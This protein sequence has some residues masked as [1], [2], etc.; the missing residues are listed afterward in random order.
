MRAKIA[1]LA[2]AITVTSVHAGDNSAKYLLA[3]MLSGIIIAASMDAKR[4]QEQAPAPVVV[5]ALSPSMP[6]GVDRKASQPAPVYVPPPA[7]VA[8]ARSKYLEACQ[9]YGFSAGDCV[10]IWDGKIIQASGQ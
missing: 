1:A 3:G 9:A 10:N 2:L 7:P 4:Q 5:R 6:S 8:T